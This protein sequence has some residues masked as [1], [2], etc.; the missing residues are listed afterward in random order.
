MLALDVHV[1]QSIEMKH[2]EHGDLGTVRV[3]HKAGKVVRLI[4]DMPRSV[5]IRVMNHRA[6]QTSFGITGEAR[7][8]VQATA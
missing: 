4:F 2:A 1:G 3:D 6:S 7:G 8:P 5:L